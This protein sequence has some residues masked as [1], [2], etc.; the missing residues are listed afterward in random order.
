MFKA[1]RFIATGTIAALVGT[2]LW[3][4][5]TGVISYAISFLGIPAFPDFNLPTR[6]FPMSFFI[7]ALIAAYVTCIA[8]SYIVS[9]SSKSIAGRWACSLG[10]ICVSIL[11]L[12]LVKEIPQTIQLMLSLCPL[13][14]FFGGDLGDRSRKLWEQ[15]ILRKE[16]DDYCQ[17]VG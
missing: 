14:T 10:L 3:V 9:Q 8:V 4:Y 5:V 7:S 1:I 6:Y 13:F 2:S 12:E 11:L 15:K 16:A 17:E